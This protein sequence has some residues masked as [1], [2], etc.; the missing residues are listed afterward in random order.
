MSQFK[1]MK[2]KVA[3]ATISKAL[4]DDL[5]EKGYHW[6]GAVKTSKEYEFTDMPHIF[7]DGT[8]CIMYGSGD[9]DYF[10][11]S[12]EYEEM[13]VV[14]KSKIVVSELVP[15]REKVVVFGKTYYKDDVDS[16]LAKLARATV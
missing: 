5:F 14:T 9:T 4:Q 10:E 2:F 6:A 11:R 16:A 8:G 1:A 13:V 3:N 15:K 7:T 12:K